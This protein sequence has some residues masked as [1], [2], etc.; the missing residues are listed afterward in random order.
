MLKKSLLKP[1]QTHISKFQNFISFCK[2]RKLHPTILDFFRIRAAKLNPSISP[3]QK[4]YVNKV[5]TIIKVFQSL[6]TLIFVKRL[7][8]SL[9]LVLC[10][11]EFKPS[12]S[13]KAKLFLNNMTV[14]FFLIIISKN[15]MLALLVIHKVLKSVKWSCLITIISLPDFFVV[16]VAFL[17]VKVASNAFDFYNPGQNISDKQ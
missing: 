3:F 12:P 2:N 5:L 16:V 7:L 17:I 8:D 13:Q 11:F 10:S 14:C 9:K 4:T 1:F 6:V 15:Y